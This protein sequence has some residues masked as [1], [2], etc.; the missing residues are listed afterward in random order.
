MSKL[1][2]IIRFLSDKKTIKFIART[3]RG[4][5]NTVKA[6]IESIKNSGLSHEDLTLLGFKS[7]KN[8]IF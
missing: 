1:K 3:V 7:H 5:K 4:S 6:Y 8:K 2:Q